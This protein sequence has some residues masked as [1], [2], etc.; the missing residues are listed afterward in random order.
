MRQSETTFKNISKGLRRYK[1]NPRNTGGLVEC[2]NLAPDK[3]E[4]KPHDTLL[5]MGDDT[6]AWGGEGVYTSSSLVRSITITVTEYGSSDVVGGVS[7]AIDGVDKGETNA[8]GVLT[9]ADVAIGRRAIIL[10]D[11]QNF[12]DSDD[13]DLYD[14][15]VIFVYDSTYSLEMKPLPTTHE[16]YVAEAVLLIHSD[17]ADEGST[18]VDSSESEITITNV[19][20]THSKT[21]KKFGASSI[22]QNT[23]SDRLNL[24]QPAELEFSNDNFTIDFWVIPIGAASED[25][26]FAKR[27]AGTQNYYITVSTSGA[28]ARLVMA[29]N[30]IIDLA[31][32][33]AIPN[34]S[35]THVEVGR[36]GVNLYLFVGGV[37]KDTD[38]TLSTK[39]VKDSAIDTY[40]GN[41]SGLSA[42]GFV[43]YLDEFHVVIGDC[44]HV[45]GFTPRT[46]PYYF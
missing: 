38:T 35:W 6:V 32:V 27:T 15:D 36:S 17:D 44:T 29:D 24:G 21:Y 11:R 23:A 28:Y 25:C 10:S 19:S 3:E 41:Y 30:S 37:V 39:E 33:A 2:F 9:I 4:L 12:Y 46:L 8:L 5:G 22:Y 14:N 13:D 18:F 7:I 42:T 40:I 26:V 34:N 1:R 31:H 20:C 45:A 16:D 43:G